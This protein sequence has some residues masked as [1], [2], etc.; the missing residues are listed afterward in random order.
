MVLLAE[1]EQGQA[2]C[3]ALGK[4]GKRAELVAGEAVDELLKF[5]ATDGAVDRW[6]ADQLLLPVDITL[7]GKPGDAAT[8]RVIPH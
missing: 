5:L 3:F 1:F 8:I 4:R 7:T 2:C 6:L